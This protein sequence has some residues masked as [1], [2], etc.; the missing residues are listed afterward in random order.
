MKTKVICLTGKA[1]CGKDTVAVHMKRIITQAGYK[2]CIMHYADLLKYLCSVL[3]GWNGEKDEAG[4]SL[5]QRIGTDVV[6]KQRP[7]FWVEFLYNIVSL[8]DGEWDYVLIPDCRFPNE[9]THFKD[10]GVHTALVR[11][12]RPGCW[13]ALTDEQKQ[14]E[15]ENAMNSF[16]SDYTIY[17]NGGLEDVAKSVIET[18]IDII[19]KEELADEG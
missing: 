16:P 17:N 1:G 14:H 7:N 10:K 11:V 4:R 13:S 15:S 9:Y 18:T 5:L 2:A 19:N 8:F 12:E 3:F 6:R